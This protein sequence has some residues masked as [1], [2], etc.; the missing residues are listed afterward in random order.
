[1]SKINLPIL[2]RTL[3]EE[4]GLSIKELA[5]KINCNEKTISFYENGERDLSI[6]TL[7]KYAD[8]FE[9]STDFLLGRTETKTSNIDH[10]K[11]CEITGLS[12]NALEGLIQ[13][14]SSKTIVYHYGLEGLNYIL[15]KNQGSEILC[16]LFEYIHSHEIMKGKYEPDFTPSQSAVSGLMSLADKT[17]KKFSDKN[18]RAKERHQRGLVINAI[19]VALEELRQDYEKENPDIDFLEDEIKEAEEYLKE[20]QKQAQRKK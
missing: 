7:Q 16:S 20:L 11:I 18:L 8:F 17:A 5:K 14:K 15:T 9:V 6:G 12:D 1:M 3:R 4:K 13:A 2:Y 10:Q 19:S